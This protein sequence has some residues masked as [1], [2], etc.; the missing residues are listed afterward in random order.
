MAG[1]LRAA[2]G[3]PIPDW[4]CEVLSPTTS[5]RDIGH[6][7]WAYHRVRVG[8]YWVADPLH[9]TLTVYRWREGSYAVALTAGAG[10]IVCAGP[11]VDAE[12]DI[13][14]MFGVVGEQG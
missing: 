14:A 2:R 4:V 3:S 9:R 6:K 5:K 7:L 12:L 13:A 10:D 8:H 1:V 11:F